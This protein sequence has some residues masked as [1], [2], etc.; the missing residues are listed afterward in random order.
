MF[1]SSNLILFS[2]VLVCLTTLLGALSDA[3]RVPTAV[4]TG[5]LGP[6]FVS[7]GVTPAGSAVA[8]GSIGSTP[9]NSFALPPVAPAV[10]DAEAVRVAQVRQLLTELDLRLADALTKLDQASQAH[11]AWGQ[12]IE[13][14]TTTDSATSSFL[15][16]QD[17]L[18]E[19]LTHLLDA[20]KPAQ[21]EIQAIRDRAMVLVLQT[22][23][24]ASESHPVLP[25]SMLNDAAAVQQK[26]Q[27]VA[28]QWANLLEQARAVVREAE[29]RRN[30]ATPHPKPDAS[31]SRGEL[32]TLQPVAHWRVENASMLAWVD[33]KA[34]QVPPATA[35]TKSKLEAA[36]E[37]KRDAAKLR[38]LNEARKLEANQEAAETA[39]RLVDE[40]LAR[41]LAREKAT[42]VKEARSSEV[43]LLLQPFLV[44]RNLQPRL[45]GASVQMRRTFEK[46][47][48]SLSA[49]QSMGALDQSVRGLEVMVRVGSHRELDVPRWEYRPSPRT[50]S[51]ETQEKLQ[52]AQDLLRRLGPTL[53]EEGLLSK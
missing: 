13:P 39:R 1:R 14:L 33:P 48:M 49:L 5:N 26:T 53:V 20:K 2:I 18:V 40:E 10:V 19:Q 27:A 8:G 15:A 38:A 25:P 30:A 11:I 22:K 35:T 17:D 23:S 21:S 52:T 36:V 12:E 24:V 50:W 9:P 3:F 29:R 4:P 31:S 6:G 34:T 44:P 32:V 45:A 42:L 41:E 46:K 37:R 47:P 16:E 7:G 28:Q 51:T 43:T